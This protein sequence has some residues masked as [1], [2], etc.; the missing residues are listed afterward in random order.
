MLLS[1]SGRSARTGLAVASALAVTALVALGGPANG[2]VTGTAPLDPPLGACSGPACPGTFPPANNGDFA[3]RDASINIFVGGD[4]LA[5]NRAAE[6]EGRI[7]TLGDLTIDKT[8]GGG[9]NMGVVGVG[10]RVPPPDGTDFVAVGGSVDIRSGNT[11][12]LGG[13]DSKGDAWGNLRHGGTLTGTTSIDPPGQ[14]I[15]DTTVRSTYAPLRSTIEERSACAAEATATGTVTIT[16]SEATFAGDGTSALQ[17]F[18][19]PGDIGGDRTIGLAFTGI[20]AGATV[21]VNMLGTSPTI[22]TYTG[23]G[24]PGDP[25]TDL[26]PRLMWN[27]PNATSAAIRGSAQFQGSVLAGRA[28]GTTTIAAPG[29]NGRVYLAGGLIQE[30]S[31][32]YELHA[33]PF[34]GVLPI[35][36]TPTPTTSAPTATP[37]TPSP[38]P[39][40]PSPTPT[41]GTPGPT[42][43]SAHPATSTPGPGPSTT[44]PATGGSSSAGHGPSGQPTV[45]PGQLADTGEQS[46]L[47][48]VLLPAGLLLTG[49]GVLRVVRRRQG[50]HS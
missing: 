38:T 6:A 36:T 41:N 12:L 9:F 20:P 2:T 45:R 8:G 46:T 21:L 16:A 18:D 15:H 5:R 13:S 47:L 40:T 10:S 35:C 49:G 33:Y 26:Q 48:T 43:S 1:V 28:A 17:V 14:A 50:R 31:G 34:T 29:L 19:V 42:D 32:G 11:L 23:S 39:T 30:G 24:V 44:A 25:T 37:T 4:Y 22:N 7:V 3:G 27:F